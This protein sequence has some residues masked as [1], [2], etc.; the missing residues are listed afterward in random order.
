MDVIISK[1]SIL[2]EDTINV[3]FTLKFIWYVKF[4]IW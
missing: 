1:N 2:E 3:S 4:E